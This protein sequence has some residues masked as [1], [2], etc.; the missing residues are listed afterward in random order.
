MNSKDYLE[1]SIRVQPFSEEAAEIV[2]AFVAD[3]PFDSFVV[4]DP[5]L[6]CYIQASLFEPA[7]LEEALAACG[8][9]SWTSRA[10]Q[11]ENWNRT[12]EQEGFTPISV[13]GTVWVGPAGHPYF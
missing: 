13:V 4:E 10:V 12:W 5:C 7:A 6:K 3:L 1:V 11:G 2:E 8:S 9:P